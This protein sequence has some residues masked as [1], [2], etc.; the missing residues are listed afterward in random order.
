MIC[1]KCKSSDLR[2]SREEGLG[3]MAANWILL[4]PYR[5]LACRKRFRAY[6]SPVDSKVLRKRLLKVRRSKATRR[7]LVMYGIAS[8]IL[9]AIIYYIVQ[10]RLSS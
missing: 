5:C 1:P 2:P 4:K 8:I 9:A 7:E 3:D 6:T 10:Q